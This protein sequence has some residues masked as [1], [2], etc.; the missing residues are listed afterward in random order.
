MR[1]ILFDTNIILDFAL[2]REP[3]YHIT[4]E[5]FNLVNDNIITAY[6]TA[7]TITDIY[8]IAAKSLNKHIAK[9]FILNLLNYVEV[10]E[11]NKSIIL[12]ALT[13]DNADFEDAIQ[14]N[15]SLRNDLD[16]IITRNKKDF[17]NSS[18][19]TFTP[20]EFLKIING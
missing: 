16:A 4:I 11:V 1:K 15:S 17:L 18:V 5:I 10:L 13:T 2:K 14:I 3:F 19:P 8:Y 20:D 12:D 6:I 9:E 7:T